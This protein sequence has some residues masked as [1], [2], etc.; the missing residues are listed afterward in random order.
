MAN[1]NTL[2]KKHL[3]EFKTFLRESGY[4]VLD[5]RGICEAVRA[6]KPGET[7]VI[8]RKMDAKE[9]LTVP[10]Q[11]EMAVRL[12]FDRRQINNGGQNGQ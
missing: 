3:E 8:Y 10:K 4:A 11:A 7:I 5:P 9:H 12:F 1:R 2:H 6:K